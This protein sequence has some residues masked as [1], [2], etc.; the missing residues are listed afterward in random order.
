[1]SETPATPVKNPF[2]WKQFWERCK[3]PIVVIQILSIIGTALVDCTP[4][5]VEV[6]IIVSIL[7]GAY[8][9]FA[10]TNNPT[11]PNGY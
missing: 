2:T 6:K 1:M 4:T 5:P 7:T 10:G 8:N 3:S 11:N 9:W